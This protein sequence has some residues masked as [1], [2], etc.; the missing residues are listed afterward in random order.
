MPITAECDDKSLVALRIGICKSDRK[1]RM[2]YEFRYA[3]G[4]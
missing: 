3:E 4:H 2:M 1:V